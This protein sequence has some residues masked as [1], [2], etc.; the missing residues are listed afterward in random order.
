MKIKNNYYTALIIAVLV[1]VITILNIAFNIRPVYNFVRYLENKNYFWA[2]PV[3]VALMALFLVYNSI[4]R[5]KIINE[6]IA[7]YNATI[8][9]CQHILHNS[10]S[11]IQL[12]ILDM[13][14]EGV[15]EELVAKAEKNIEDLKTVTEVLASI[16]PKNMKLNELNK[17]LSIINIE[18]IE[19]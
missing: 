7:I 18:G 17:N 8:R 1:V 19:K 9:T 5:K 13:K 11:S 16:D 6:R 2:I 3:F 4:M 10:Y 12:L 14:D 15:K